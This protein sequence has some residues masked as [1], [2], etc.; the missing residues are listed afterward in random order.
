MKNLAAFCISLFIF[1]QIQGQQELFRLGL[2]MGHTNSVTDA[3]FSPDGKFI[4]SVSLDQTVKLWEVESGRLIYS[5]IWHGWKIN[6]V[7]F[8]F[9]G[10]KI[11][12]SSDDGTAIIWDVEKGVMLYQLSGH[13]DNVNYAEFSPDDKKIITISDDK[14]AKIWEVETGRLLYDLVGHTDY[15]IFAQFSSDGKFVV[16]SSDDETFKIWDTE[17]GQ[18]LQ[19]I[20]VD[21]LDVNTASISPNCTKI[22]TGSLSRNNPAQIWNVQSGKI[23][24]DL[25]GH[26]SEVK[27]AEFSPNGALVATASKDKTIK[28][29]DVQTGQLLFNLFGHTSVVK[30]LQFSPNGKLLASISEDKTAKLWNVETGRL[31]Y[32]FIKDSEVL[33]PNQKEQ[34]L[35]LDGDTLDLY[36]KEFNSIDFSVDGK[37]IIVASEDATVVMWNIE[38]GQLLRTFD[39]HTISAVIA[40]FSPN[41][42]SIV[43]NNFDATLWDIRT[44]IMQTSLKGHKEMVFNFQFS[45]NGNLIATVSFDGTAKIW[46]AHTGHHLMS[47]IGHK[48]RVVSVEFSPDGNKIVTSSWDK[49]AKVWDV[50]SGNL[51]HTLTGH[52]NWVSYSQ[53]FPDG[54]RL[55]TA[56]LDGTIKLFDANTGVQIG[57]YSGFEE[58]VNLLK[59]SPDAEKIIVCAGNTVQLR[60]AINGDVSFNLVGHNGWIAA[61]QFSPNGNK[62]VTS[63]SDRTAK[64]WDSVNGKLLNSLNGHT[65]VVN[66]VQFSPNGKYIVTASYDHTA[67]IWNSE[68]GQLL[69]NLTG[70]NDAVTFAHFSLNGQ[71]VV[72]A[73][74]DT[75]CKIWDLKSGNEILSFIKTDD[76]NYVSLLPSSYFR[77]SQKAASSLYYIKGLKTLGFDQLDI[78]Y[79]RPD[80]VL[81]AL[82]EAFGSPDT[83]LIDSYYRAWLKR[84]QKLGIDTTSFEEGFSVPESDFLNR[85]ELQFE[86]ASNQIKLRV[87]GKDNDYKLDRF[88]VWVNEVPVFGQKGI[89]IRNRN[90]N[91]MDTTIIINLSVGDNKIETSVMNVNGIESFRIPLYLQHHPVAKTD[92]KLFFIGIGIDKYQQPGFD[93]K[94]SSKDIRDMTKHLKE[95]YGD[96]ISIDTLINENATLENIEALKNKLLQSTVNDKVIVLFSGHGLLN[97]EFDYFLSTYDIDFDQPEIKG[98]PYEE[99]EWLLDSIPSR[100][101]LLLI[102]ACHSGEVDKE[103]LLAIQNNENPYGAK[104]ENLFYKYRPKIGMKNS[105][106][107]MQELFANVNRGTGATIISAAGGTQFAYE[108]GNLQNGVFT[109]SILELMQ[110]QDEINVSDLK[111]KVG[112]RVFEL[113]NGLQKPTSR[114][115]TIENN[116]T[117]W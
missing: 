35:V 117:V 55:I 88:N 82:G 68:N 72:T 112:E 69:L 52:T 107:L 76:D 16:T 89:N 99:L 95:K 94:Y 23:E 36:T 41:G 4:A 101:K 80:K 105:F 9:T 63:S 44:G 57:E 78:K 26:S 62:I 92:D 93:L 6:S 48:D 97:D 86:Q 15:V 51:N 24:H 13:T 20:F 115:E 21:K 56:S 60:N 73:S 31:L 66:S 108:K 19:D 59:F 40:R 25:I 74:S 47:Y 38:N 84:V 109:Y 32:T 71:M 91:E 33:N 83:L 116:W 96:V 39:G 77:C 98:L 11:V 22:I 28:I 53:F 111:S 103:E 18:V 102:D 17:S 42:K 61:A 114:N 1:F 79:N 34:K 75:E 106:E 2:P 12:T 113:T 14:T 27:D 45:P 67:K 65:G 10:K 110:Q 49:T 54:K 87:W 30:N 58:G 81:T 70:H 3:Q 64:I 7:R 90:L 37:K 5:M 29:W 85:G 8:N 100:K 104:G 50:R 43:S 46:D